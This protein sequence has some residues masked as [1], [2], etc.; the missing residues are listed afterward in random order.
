MA[1][2]FDYFHSYFRKDYDST[3]VYT[4]GRLTRRRACRTERA[5]GSHKKKVR[6][7]DLRDGYAAL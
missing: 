5:F 7:I 6:P 1:R 2:W 4:D 3:M